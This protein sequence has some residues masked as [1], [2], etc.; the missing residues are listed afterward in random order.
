MKGLGIFLASLILL[1]L[2]QNLFVRAGEQNGGYE[3]GMQQFKAF[4]ENSLREDAVV[5]SSFMLVHDN[6][7]IDKQFY[8]LANIQQN[9]K[10]DE[11]TIYHWASITK[12][13]TGIAIMQ[14]RDRGRLK[15]DDPI[16]KYIP[17]L[18]EV[19]DPYGDMSEITI[20]MLMSHTA[21]F[22]DAT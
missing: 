19:H 20:R 18:R 2:L 21:G 17:E 22:R 5:G 12:T 15:L 9:R 16:I 7:V 10:V 1:L 6:Q 4:Y 13:F 14:L 8:G 11:N 3:K